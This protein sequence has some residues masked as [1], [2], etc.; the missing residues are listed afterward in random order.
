MKQYD[1]EE[2]QSLIDDFADKSLSVRQI[3]II[4]DYGKSLS[5]KEIIDLWSSLVKSGHL[6]NIRKL[7][8]EIGNYLVNIV[9]NVNKAKKSNNMKTTNKKLST[10][11]KLKKILRL[12]ENNN[13]KRSFEEYLSDAM[14]SQEDK[15]PENTDPENTDPEK[16]FKI[17]LQKINATQTLNKDIK[18]IE[19]N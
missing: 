14:Q 19:R 7:H 12:K 1:N 2:V 16:A 10:F 8:R 18:D 11:E 3:K 6:E 5:D 15:N 9:N 17:F 4:A 13:S